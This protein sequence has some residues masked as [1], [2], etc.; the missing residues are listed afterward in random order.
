M[1]TVTFS[2]RPDD[3]DMQAAVAA[4]IEE[5][6]AWRAEKERRRFMCHAMVV[7][8][9]ETESKFDRCENPIVYTAFC[10]S[11]GLLVESV[12][13]ADHLGVVQH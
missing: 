1:D 12:L 10:R 7:S 2:V 3:P 11:N 9:S 4:E 5:R 8:R 6:E 13:C